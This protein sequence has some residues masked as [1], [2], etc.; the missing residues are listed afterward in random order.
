MQE[1]EEKLV[2]YELDELC[3]WVQDISKKRLGDAL[4]L[5]GPSKMVW[6]LYPL[7]LFWNLVVGVLYFLSQLRVTA[8]IENVP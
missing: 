5:L 7:S 4:S 1:D 8:N 2:K 3:G 6:K